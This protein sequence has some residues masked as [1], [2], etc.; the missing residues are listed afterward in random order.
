MKKTFFLHLLFAFMCVELKF[1][2]FEKENAFSLHCVLWPESLL[3]HNLSSIRVSLLWKCWWNPIGCLKCL[4]LLLMRFHDKMLRILV[5]IF[6]GFWRNDIWQL[7]R[8]TELEKYIFLY[9][10]H[11]AKSWCS[12]SLHARTTLVLEILKFEWF[13]I[14]EISLWRLGSVFFNACESRSKIS[15]TY[16]IDDSFFTLDHAANS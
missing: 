4:A 11:C 9:Q 15:H 16:F 7:M 5:S 12:K 10:R 13:F 3:T 14:L 1:Y 6:L 8:R 2:D